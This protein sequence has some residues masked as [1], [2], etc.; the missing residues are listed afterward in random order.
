MTLNTDRNCI[1]SFC[2][3]SPQQCELR[4]VSDV[5]THARAA[6]GVGATDDSISWIATKRTVT[7]AVDRW[8]AL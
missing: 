5:C 3:E 6:V 2:L 7:S 1:K 8:I 4:W